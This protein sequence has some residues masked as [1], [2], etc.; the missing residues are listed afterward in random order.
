MTLEQ[1]LFMSF[2]TGHVSNPQTVNVSG[3]TFSFD[4]KAATP[5]VVVKGEALKTLKNGFGESDYVVDPGF[6]G[7]ADGAKLSGDVWSGDIVD[8]S[9]TVNK[10]A[11]GDQRLVIN[12]N[13]K[14]I[15]LSTEI[16]GLKA[17]TDYVAEFYVENESDAKTEIIVNTGSKTV[18]NYTIKS[19]AGDSFSVI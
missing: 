14:N 5:Y 9:V 4:A 18:S 11:T 6:N 19:I 2:Q 1:L 3:D 8:A 12:N 16:S 10:A 17:G 7:Y 13:S 15:A